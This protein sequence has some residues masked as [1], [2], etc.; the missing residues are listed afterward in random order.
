MTSDLYQ[1]IFHFFLLSIIIAT[2]Y[3]GTLN[4]SWHFDDYINIVDDKNIR[5][6]SLS[7]EHIK[8]PI[9]SKD[10]DIR[11]RPLAVLSF[12]GNYL[13]SGLDTTGYHVVN[14]LIHII[15][16][17]FVYLVFIYTLNLYRQQYKSSITEDLINDIALFGAVL[18]AIHPIQTQA[19]TYIVQRMASMAAMFYM[20]SLYFYLKFRLH[21]EAKFKVLLIVLSVLSWGA[22]ILSKENAALL[23]LSIIAYEIVIFRTSLKDNLRFKLFFFGSLISLFVFS[24]I[25][26]SGDIISYLDKTYSA[27]PYTMWE[28]LI[29]QPIILT[30]YIFLLLVPVADFLTLD[31]NIF[32]SKGLFSP[33]ITIFANLFIFILIILS[34]Y[35]SRK[36]PLICFAIIFY[37]INHLV[38]STIIGLELYFE[39]RNYLPSVFIYLVVS[40]FFLSICYHYKKQGRMFM[41]SLFVSLIFFI[42]VSEGNATYLRNDV[43]KDDITLYSDNLDKAP[44]NIRVYNNLAA[45]YMKL[46]Q[47]EKALEYLKQAEKI[48]KKY[49][50]SFQKN[51]VADIYCNAGIIYLHA[52]GEIE[53]ASQL[54]LKS[55][56]LFS[57]NFMVHYH[58]AIACFKLGDL[59]NAETAIINAARL[60]GGEAPIYNLLGRI[61]YAEGKYDLAVKAFDKGLELEKERVLYLNCVASYLA[62]GELKKAR[63]VLFVMDAKDDDLLYWLYRLVVATEPE[64]DDLISTIVNLLST[65][66]ISFEK[67]VAELSDN[68]NIQIIFPD[69][70]SFQNDL[71]QPFPL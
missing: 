29:T 23:P 7:W 28:R 39:H 67:L 25:F 60:N 5:I 56:E 41:Y 63:S 34:I 71:Y 40:Y 35:F 9:Y 64:K 43:W 49:P 46:G 57:A 37:F 69:I 59:P 3:S 12:A 27:R 33:P 65:G 13:F 30:R 32:A 11:G 4:N 21:K 17:F 53:K 68:N 10:G 8:K 62:L 54:L 19:V 15:C 70:S 16:S 18:W 24:L 42:V 26:M 20:I 51:S 6:D 50:D 55:A 66:H 38:E 36:Y 47:H 61:L 45:E 2:C 44:L 48:Y 22:G 14:I 58:L 1:K 31:T 52:K